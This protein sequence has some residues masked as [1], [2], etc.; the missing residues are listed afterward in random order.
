MKLKFYLVLFLILSFSIRT[1][2]AD[3]NKIL[4]QETQDFDRYIITNTIKTSSP[5]IKQYWDYEIYKRDIEHNGKILY[6]KGQ[7]AKSFRKIN[8]KDDTHLI[9]DIVTYNED[10]SVKD[11][12]KPDSM[13]W[14]QIV[15]ETAGSK[16]RDYIC[17]KNPKSAVI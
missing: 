6:S 15:P 8:C 12:G 1:A 9:L 7:S 16:M 3:K 13:I 17:N 2:I 11:H 4:V 5:N 14:L 10:G